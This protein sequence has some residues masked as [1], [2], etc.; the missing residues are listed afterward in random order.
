[1]QRATALLGR[2]GWSTWVLAALVIPAHCLASE[3]SG[4][5]SQPLP[6]AAPAEGVPASTAGW[7][8][9]AFALDDPALEEIDLR[10]LLEPPAGKHGFVS[11]RQDGHLYFQDGTRVRFFGTNVGGASCV[12][13]KKTAEV[14]AARLARFGV[15]MLRLHT[16]DARWGG[17]ID[18]AQ[19]NT[20]SLNPE[21][22]DRYD[23]F[24]AQLKRHG[25]YVYFDLLDYRK[26]LPGDGVRDAEQMGTRWEHSIKGA[27]I[28]D[29]RMIELQK[30]FATQLLTHRNPYTGLRYV[31]E[32][33]LAV[34]EITNENSLFYLHNQNLMLPSYVEDLRRLWNGWLLR[35]FADRAGL[36]RAWTNDRGECALLPDEDPASNTVLCPTRHL[37]ADL[38]QAPYVGER[39]PARLNALTRFLYEQQSAYFREMAEHLRSIGLKCPITGTNQDFSDASNMANAVGDCMSRNNYWH[40]P[41]LNVKPMQ[42]HNAPMIASDIVKSAT[43]VAQVASSAVAGKPLIVPEFNAPWPNDY[44]AECL[45]LMAAYGRLQDWDGLL[46]FAYH[47]DRQGRE[48]L[49]SF[50]T[51]S[52]PVHWGQIPLA[53]LVF[54][55]G[56]IAPARNTIHIGISRTDSF[57]TRPQRNADRYS[58]YRVLPYLSKVRNAYFEERYPGGA[59]AAVASGH[60]SVG[61]YQQAKHAIVFADSPFVDERAIRADRGLSARQTCPGLRTR[62]GAGD[63]DTQL[64]PDSIPLGSRLIER[65]GMPVGF[66]DARFCIFPCASADEPQDPAWLHRLYLR[67]ANHWDLPGAGPV[68]DAGNMFRSDTGELVLDR[69]KGLFTAVAPKVVLAV[70]YLADAGEFKLGP[71]TIACQTP[72]GALGLVSLDGEALERS[73]RLLLT[74]VARSE[75]P[76]QAT[77]ALG[78]GGTA[79]ARPAGTG[80]GR[81]LRT[82]QHALREAGRTPVLA[83]PVNAEVRL[84]TTSRLRAYALDSRA[85]KR[86][87]LPLTGDGRA[88]IIR[89]HDARSPW[90]LLVAE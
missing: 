39:S 4:V 71:A 6:G 83:E 24:V 47:P 8:P 31:D 3:S 60:S 16:P 25:I 72:F 35:G 10:F 38:R 48:L 14:V 90:L 65:A 73:G 76:G 12:P 21:A 41:N 67:M 28:F 81:V 13:D 45:P 5:G 11:V 26:F 80:A 75:N 70:G 27:S 64:V 42:F 53:A 15:N 37:Y 85:R 7:Y 77:E 23:Y 89:T 57:A 79:A 61:D 32:P 51:Q 20:R 30:E 2:R 86:A 63:F 18:Y 66:Y 19:G 87:A 49:T 59:D 40:H 43:L 44:R 58:P 1:M 22:L 33:A 17:F 36:A 88:A 62:P 34:Q 29:R 56:D 9:W 82:G 55:R 78:R 68:E 74:A 84:A 69:Q 52:D 50:G 46:F 54:L